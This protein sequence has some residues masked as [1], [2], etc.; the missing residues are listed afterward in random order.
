MFH[1]MNI[2]LLIHEMYLRI[3]YLHIS[4]RVSAVDSRYSLTGNLLIAIEPGR[5]FSVDRLAFWNGR[6]ERSLLA[7]NNN[8]NL[9]DNPIT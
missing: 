9:A 6:H 4:I 7:V 8:N 5:E 2:C 3:V 1:W